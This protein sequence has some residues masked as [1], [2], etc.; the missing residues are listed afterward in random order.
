MRL[1]TV[2]YSLTSLFLIMGCSPRLL[3]P[4]Q[5]LENQLPSTF[6]KTAVLVSARM[7]GDL[8]DK[9]IVA[10]RDAILLTLL[11]SGQYAMVQLEADST[12]PPDAD[13]YFLTLKRTGNK[14]IPPFQ[15]GRDSLS[16]QGVVIRQGIQVSQFTLQSQS[17][18]Q[19]W[20]PDHCLIEQQ[21]WAEFLA[22]IRGGSTQE[23]L[24]DC[25][26]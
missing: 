7:E 14:A 13:Q 21:L 17:D 6:A 15:H 19:L 1:R 16:L 3:C 11:Q 8:E 18:P 10:F 20:F 4:P 5:E 24:G 25:G 2:I 12:T 23:L 26:C 9:E 22:W